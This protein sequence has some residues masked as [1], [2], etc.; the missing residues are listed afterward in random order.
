MYALLFISIFMFAFLLIFIFIFH[1][2]PTSALRP[3]CPADEE[4]EKKKIIIK[5]PKL[6]DDSFDRCLI[7]PQKCLRPEPRVLFLLFA[8]RPLFLPPSLPPVAYPGREGK[9]KR[10]GEKVLFSI[11]DRWY[12]S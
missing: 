3:V 9:E 12:A 1:L 6:A 8:I 4:T 11:C 10:D 7:F 2:C 5:I